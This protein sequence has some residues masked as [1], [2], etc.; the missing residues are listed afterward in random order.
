MPQLHV[1]VDD[2]VVTDGVVAEGVLADGVFDFFGFY[3]SE[4]SETWSWAV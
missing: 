1:V 4:Q 2:G 3:H